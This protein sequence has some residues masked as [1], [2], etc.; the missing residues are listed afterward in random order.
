GVVEPFLDGV[1]VGDDVLSPGWSAYQHRVR[2]REYD[3]S[4]ALVDSGAAEPETAPT[5]TAASAEHELTLLVGNGWFTGRIGWFGHR[6]WYGSRRGASAELR[7][8]FTDGP[9]WLL[10]TGPDWRLTRSTVLEDD[11]YDGMLIDTRVEPGE[12]AAVEVLDFDRSRLVADRGPAIVRHETIEPVR[13]DRIAPDRLIVDFGQNLVGWVR[14]ATSGDRGD[15]LTVRHAEVL[16]NGEL[17]RRPL[18]SAEA[19]DRYVLSG[20]ADTFE[21]TLTTHGFRYAELQGPPGVLDG[22]GV[23]AVVVGSFLRRTGHFDCSDPLLNRLHANVVWSLRGNTVGIPTDCPQRDERLGWTGDIAVFAPAACF[24]FDMSAFL[25]EWLADLRCEQAAY[26]G[27]VPYVVPDVLGD[28]SVDGTGSPESVAVWSDA[29]VWVPWA[30]WQAGGD[31]AVLR[32]SLPSMV[33]H[34]DRVAGLLSPDGVWDRGAQFG[35]WLDPAAPPDDPF[36]AMSDTGVIATAAFHRSV[37]LTGKAARILGDADLTDRMGALAE[38]I[39]AGFAHR[40]VDRDGRI[41]SDTASVYALAIVSEVVDARTAVLA[42]GHLARRVRRNGHTVSTGFVGTAFVCEALTRTGHLDDAYAMLTCTRHPSWL[43]PVA[44]GATTVWERWDSLLADGR[45]NPGEMTS[46]NHYAL[47]AVADWMHRTIGGIV[48]LEPGYARVRIAPRPGG[49]ISWA[50]TTLDT[51]HGTVSVSWRT[52][53][54]WQLT[55]AAPEGVEVEIVEPAEF[56]GGFDGPV[57]DRAGWPPAER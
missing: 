6:G 22:T 35:D 19:T 9:P 7:V 12:P 16:E 51:S 36:A 33:S 21:P 45:V 30:L 31:L 15:R 25:R 3:L 29:A 27:R 40:Y 56:T 10:L 17:A 39:R 49:G 34:V 47:G 38:R 28:W 55:V 26:A 52:E 43:H 44:L 11:L 32:E 46:F 5:A 37:D 48:P 13:L 14:L 2:Y 20:A 42:G 1:R 57:A 54:R 24:L 18:R 23:A 8:E 4:G 50:N 41:R 53:P